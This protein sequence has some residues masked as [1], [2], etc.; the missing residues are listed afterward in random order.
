MFLK[1]MERKNKDRKIACL[2]RSELNSIEKI[3]NNALIDSD[4]SQKITE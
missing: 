2:A 1:A 4:I 3:I